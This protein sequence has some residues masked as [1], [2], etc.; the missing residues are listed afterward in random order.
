[1]LLDELPHHPGPKDSDHDQARDEQPAVIHRGGMVHVP[2]Y[3][4]GATHRT[5]HV[6]SSPA[7]GDA[8][9]HFFTSSQA[10]QTHQAATGNTHPL[11]GSIRKKFLKINC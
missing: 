9:T 6:L 3:I 11:P 4:Q 8:T 1:M 2:D 7:R 10:P 5:Q